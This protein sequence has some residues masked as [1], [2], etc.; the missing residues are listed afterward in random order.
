MSG[1]GFTSTEQGVCAARG[2]RA[3][4]VAAGIR[5][6]GGPDLVVLVSDQPAA[7]AGT[8]T[9]H[10]AAAAP[11]RISRSRV[12]TGSARGVVV[13]SGCANAVT[14][15]RGLRDAED[16]AAAAAGAVGAEPVEMLV[17]STGKIGSFLPMDRVARGIA[18]AAATL[19]ASLEADEAVARAILTTDT[20]PKRAAV[21]HD[22]GWT[23]GGMAKGAGMIAPNMATMLAFLTTDAEIPADLLAQALPPVVASTFNTITVDGE[24]ST[25]DTVLIFANGASGVTPSPAE[26]G[27]AL[28]SVCLSLAEAIVA[29]GEGAT[30]FVRVRVTGAWSVEEAARAARCVA[31]SP[32]VKAALFGSD[33][34]WGRVAAA[35]GKADVTLDLDALTLGMGGV[36]LYD[37]GLATGDE[38]LTRAGEALKAREIAI[39][40]D[41]GVGDGEAT[42]LTTDL[43][44]GYVEINAEYEP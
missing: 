42:I 18:E 44:F 33:P 2:F 1:T 11:V 26:L 20:R 30:K 15:S 34:N 12:Q 35:L 4:G 24:P 38:A 27:A 16:M 31:D 25:N 22:S 37:S 40:C 29:D 13:N 39:D 10:K 6:S 17:C 21:V 9:T 43:S 7:V 32:L 28:E 41:L 14:G 23:L 8:F 5:A 19:G 36:T 3:A